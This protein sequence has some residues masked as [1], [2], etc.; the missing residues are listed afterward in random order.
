MVSI[1]GD[2]HASFALAMFYSTPFYPPPSQADFN[3][4]WRNEENQVL[5][6]GGT[7]FIGSK[8]T[9]ATLKVQVVLDSQLYF[10]D[11][12][13]KCEVTFDSA[14]TTRVSGSFSCRGLRNGDVRIDAAGAFEAS[15]G[16]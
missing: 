10:T 7:P 16:T 11:L 4:V 6:L 1:S 9:Q 8:R 12:G 15:A 5:G 14:S 2:R 13:G 3:L